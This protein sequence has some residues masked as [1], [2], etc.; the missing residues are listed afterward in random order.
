MRYALVDDIVFTDINGKEYTIKD[1]RPYEQFKT[2]AKIKLQGEK[3]LDEIATRPEYYGDDAEGESYKIA[4]ANIVK[5]FEA[6][7]DL[8]KIKELQVPL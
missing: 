6:D 4:D 8:S 7:F 3:Y 5:L 2:F 1:F